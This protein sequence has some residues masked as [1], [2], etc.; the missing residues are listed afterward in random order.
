[1]AIVTAFHQVKIKPASSWIDITDQV[2]RVT[3]DITTSGNRDNALAFGEETIVRCSIECFDT[4]ASYTYANIPAEVVFAI[5][6]SSV[7][8]FSGIIERR[9][10]D[11]GSISLTFECAGA[12]EMIKATKVY[13][14][15]FVKRYAATKT[16]VSSNEDPDSVGY[17]AG[18]INY[19][20]WKAGGRPYEQQGNPTYA[21]EARF[22]YSCDQAIIAPDYVCS[23]GDDAWGELLRLAKAVGGQIYQRT[24][25]VMQYRQTT[26]AGVGA[27]SY[28]F[29]ENTYE[30]LRETGTTGQLATKIICPHVT[31]GPRPMQ[32][33][34]NDSSPRVIGA[35]ATV[36][37]ELETQ[38]PL[39]NVEGNGGAL[40]S[41]QEITV[42]SLRSEAIQAAYYDGTPVVQ[43]GSG[44]SHSITTS[45]QKLTISITNLSARPFVIYRLVLRAQPIAP[46]ASGTVSAGEE[47]FEM[48]ISDNPFIQ[49]KSHALR[50]AKM[51]L[52][53][54]SVLRPV[55][56]ISGCV[57]STARTVGEIVGLSSTR[58][59]FSAVPHIIIA[60]RHDETG[61]RSEYDLIPV[62]DLPTADQFY[63]AGP[64]YAGATEYM[65]TW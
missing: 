16:T 10:R 36:S 9:D 60:I 20:F 6:G 55:R 38:W 65:L 21:T 17:K 24:N 30:R 33:V 3:G 4:V 14:P 15:L 13:S 11:D 1:M 29:D 37:I 40:L 32:E 18:P 54:Y 59:G 8:A 5:S 25:G 7:I 27:A 49:S 48:S 51:T 56:T 63:A 52:A 57:F 43:G 41:C 12:V 47:G 34:I 62:N 61:A 46:G 26:T 39:L 28:T 2:I 35:S 64:D 58:W 50:L 23:A 19:L 31:R 45:G 22:W 44:Y 42:G 53:F